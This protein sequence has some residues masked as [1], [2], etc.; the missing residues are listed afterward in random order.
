M[1]LPS[2]LQPHFPSP[3]LILVADSE[4]IVAWMAHGESLEEQSTIAVPHEQ[5]TDNEASFVNTVTHGTHGP[6]PREPHDDDHVKHWL[7]EAT[8]AIK[9]TEPFMHLN[10]AMPADYLRALEERLTPDVRE[11][12][13]RKLEANV[14]KEPILEVIER[15]YR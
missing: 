1:K 6:S 7:H 3:T 15:L 12:I 10:L 9:K 8:E 2:H 4:H 5:K 14:R 13:L 11:R